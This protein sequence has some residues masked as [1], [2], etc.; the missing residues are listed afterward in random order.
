MPYILNTKEDVKDMLKAIGMSSIEELYSLLPSK[1]KLDSPFNIPDSKSEQEVKRIIKGLSEKNNPVEKFNSFLGAGC[2]DHYI[3]AALS[4]ILSR[5]QFLTAYTPYQAECSQGILQAIYEYQSFLCLLT[6]MDVSNASLLDGASALSEAILMSLRITKRKKVILAGAIHPEYKETLYTYLSG[7]DFTIQ[8]IEAGDDGL[9]DRQALSRAVDQETASCVFSSPNFFGLI[10]N[11]DELSA[12]AKTKGS[13]AIM[14]TNPL[15]LAIFKEP[16]LLGVDIVCGDGQPLGGA[17]N[18]GGPSFGFLTTV[19]DYLR[20]IPGRIVGKTKDREMNNAYC[21]TLQVREQHIRREKAT[22]NICS[23]QSLNAIAA[24]VY[25]SLIGRDGLKD[26]AVYSLSNT[27]YLYQRLKEVRGVNIPYSS[28]VFNEFVW[29]VEDAPRIIAELYK[30]NIIVGYYLGS[31]LNQ[32]KN[33][34]LSCCTEKKSK[35]EI[36]SFVNF[37]GEVLH[38]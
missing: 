11:S 1:I 33:S 4:F 3:P 29:E 16:R 35:E 15:S 8:E 34:I 27:Q 12:I 38:G 13:L 22:S 7:F 18:F 17:L 20:Q 9:V 21:L 37:L 19:K 2:Y 32:S 36:D 31:N 28:C 10:E 6:G 5:S 26:S 30:K 23:N 14:L 25:L 24:A